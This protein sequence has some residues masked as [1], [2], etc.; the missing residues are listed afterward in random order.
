MKSGW[1]ERLR[2][3][4][5]G[6]GLVRN[7]GLAHLVA[8]DS[9]LDGR[10]ITL[11]GERL[12][13]FGSCS[14][15]GLETDERLKNAAC[16]AVER[17]G[18]VFSSSRAY[19]SVPLFAEYERLMAELVG[20]HPVVLAPSTSLAHQAA[21]PVLVG[22][23][24]AVCYDV[25]VHS[26]VQAVLPTLL[27]RGVPCEP[28]PHNRLD[29]LERRARRLAANHER[30]FYLCDGVYS[31]HGDLADLA[32]L[33]DLMERMPALFAYVDDAHG[34]G[35]AGRHGAGVVLGERGLHERMAV[36][37]SLSKSFATGGAIVT[38]HDRELARR[39]FSCGAPLIFSGPLQPAQLGAGIASALI[40]LSPEIGALQ[41]RL[42]VRIRLFDELSAALGVEVVAPS[43]SPIRF[44]EIG[45]SEAAIEVARHLRAA[46]FF[47]NISVFPAVAHGRAGVRLMLTCQHTAEDVAALVR[48][49]ARC[50]EAQ[51]PKSTRGKRS[52]LTFRAS[53]PS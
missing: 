47:L 52:P 19:V 21:L 11:E 48:E 6:I 46:G 45:R 38:V 28:I 43:R 53:R 49:L 5:A 24:D 4:E 37:L 3:I 15:L 34:V 12:I 17:Y 2:S 39:I 7:A 14:Y 36:A 35:W 51:N 16:A 13:N 27:Q 30:V 29:L 18:V 41:E 26:S 32:G 25:M 33:S 20:R 23:R 42:R 31:M 22:E 1:N 8:E 40:H 9:R 44:I 10:Q 50:L